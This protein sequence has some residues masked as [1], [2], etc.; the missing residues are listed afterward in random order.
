ML[1]PV[2]KKKLERKKEKKRLSSALR[3]S[4]VSLKRGVSLLFFSLEYVLD[5]DV[6]REE[7]YSTANGQGR[8]IF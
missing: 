7:E 4:D 1:V 8:N 3:S 2:E 6:T 5:L